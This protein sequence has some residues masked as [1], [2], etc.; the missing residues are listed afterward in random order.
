MYI[1][2]HVY[3]TTKPIRTTYEL[4]MYL[5]QLLR[6]ESFI[7]ISECVS[8]MCPYFGVIPLAST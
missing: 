6:S 4:R 1:Y 7:N 2:I 3:V 8:N 5:K